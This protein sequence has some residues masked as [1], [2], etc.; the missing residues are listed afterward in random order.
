MQKASL[1]SPTFIVG[2]VHTG[3]S[4]VYR[5]L[6]RHPVVFGGIGETWFFHHFPIIR[7]HFSA[8]DNEPVFRDYVYYLSHLILNGYNAV[9]MNALETNYETLHKYQLTEAHLDEIYREALLRFEDNRSHI[10]IYGFVYD[11]LCTLC[12]KDRWVE[13][14]PGHLYHV[15]QI[16][17]HFPNARVIEMVRDPRGILASKKRRRDASNVAGTHSKLRNAALYV[18]FD[19]LLDTLGWRSAIGAGQA[20]SQRYP[21]QVLRVHYENFVANPADECLRVGE[22]LDLPLNTSDLS[23]M[24]EVSWVNTTIDRQH[25]KTGIGTDAIHKWHQELN[26]DEIAICQLIA[27]EKIEECNYERLQ[28][29]NRAL[30]KLP[31]SMLKSGFELVSQLYRQQRHGGTSYLASKLGNLF[32][33]LKSVSGTNELIAEK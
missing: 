29:P 1:Q 6:K 2:S 9:N 12:K 21:E 33:R 16:V 18:R 19:P 10:E 15:D 17:K 24:L 8:L 20:A 11:S 3:T 25:G 30:L 13:K 5:I 31:W 22:F 4:L 27:N 7:G 32:R 26:S 28:I 14:T 23:Q